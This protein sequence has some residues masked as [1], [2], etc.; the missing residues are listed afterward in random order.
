V[1]PAL[2]LAARISVFLF[3]VL[4]ILGAGLSLS[5]Q[6]SR[7]PFKSSRLVI[8][9][10]AANFVLVPL[11]AYL[12]TKAIPM[13]KSL[14]IALLL[15]G[16]ASGAPVLPKLVEFARG[17]LELGVGLMTLLMA[18]TI[19]TMPLALPMLLPGAHTNTWSIA[20]PLLLVV[21]PSL[22]AGLSLQAYRKILAARLQPTIRLASN[23]ALGVVILVS[24]ATNFSNIGRTGSLNAVVAGAA[25]FIVSYG[26]GFALGG[27]DPGTRKVLGLA[28]ASRGISIAS[29]VAIE[30]FR[31][32]AVVNLLAIL[33]LIAFVILV[34]AALTLGA[35][36]THP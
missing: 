33:A 30:N 36:T 18:G 28:T 1:S 15:L 26:I 23:V 35:R 17:N 20:K 6:Q 10:L 4:S 7:A 31:G 21:I 22:T 5:V 29:L 19:L 14:A 25:L 3:V 9:A 13:D 11:A 8:S 24:I 2:E 16:A 27:P 32:P 12:I 34:P